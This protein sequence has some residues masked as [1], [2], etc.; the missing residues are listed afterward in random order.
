MQYKHATLLLFIV[1]I[2]TG[3]LTVA[4]FERRSALEEMEELAA[5]QLDE[6]AAGD[7]L[8]ITYQ[9]LDIDF[10]GDGTSEKVVL[11]I[12]EDDI[13]GNVV[14]LSV[15]ESSVEVDG[16][17]SQGY[18][19]LVDLN[20]TD[21]WKEIAISD[22]GPSS[23]FSTEFYRFDGSKLVKIGSTQGLFEDMV[24]DG[25]GKL[26]T[27]TRGSIL[28][29]WFFADDYMLIDGEL[30]HVD[31]DFYPRLDDMKVTMSSVMD[32]QISPADP[33]IAFSTVANDV[34]T[35]VGCD[36]IEWCKAKNTSNVEGWFSVKTT[37]LSVFEGLSTAD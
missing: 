18:F 37:D 32:F 26:T 29:T 1:F 34:I 19:S 27:T 6:T 17:N 22:L 13:N 2:G 16:N 31:K 28:D 15:N 14:T 23:D 10:N 5:I 12:V 9:S 21:S 8:P 25:A 30:Q 11:T 36:N 4:V 24:F 3:I 35:I 20:A 33:L 7:G